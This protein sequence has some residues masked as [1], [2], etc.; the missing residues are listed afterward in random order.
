MDGTQTMPFVTE[1]EAL[2]QAREFAQVLA[3]APEFR[4][5]EVARERLTADRDATALLQ[6]L[7]DAQQKVAMLQTW[8]GIA[9][10][11]LAELEWLRVQAFENPV[12]KAV[13]E[14][15]AALLKLFQNAAGIISAAVGL[16]FGA[17]CSP[18]GGCC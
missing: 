11:E 15:Q 7:Q 16:D 2:A 5:F 17:A 8:G 4:A 13:F 14:A 10:N 18:A 6:R 1:A 3:R 12:I 9:T